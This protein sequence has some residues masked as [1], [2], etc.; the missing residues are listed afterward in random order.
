MLTEDWY[1]YQPRLQVLAFFL[2]GPG[3]ENIWAIDSDGILG[4]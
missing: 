3:A 2:A 1:E 4:L